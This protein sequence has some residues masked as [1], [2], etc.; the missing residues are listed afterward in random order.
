MLN[1]ARKRVNNYIIQI[2]INV[3]T[4]KNTKEAEF[5]LF[6]KKREFFV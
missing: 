2:Q 5:S 4:Y 3:F 6:D 1:N